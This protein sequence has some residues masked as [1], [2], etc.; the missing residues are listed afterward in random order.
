MTL[1]A[2]LLDAGGTLL[3]EEPS[4]EAL[5]AQAATRRG[6]DLSPP[7]MRQCMLRAHAALPLILDGNFRYS[8][9]WFE[10]FIADV[11]LRQLGLEP[12]RLHALVSEL[13]ETFADAANFR[14]LPGA[15]ELL[16]GAKARGWKLGLISNWSESM[17]E[18]LAGLG[19]LPLFDSVLI[20]AIER[21]E[22]PQREIFQRALA[23]LNVRADEALHLGN[24]PVQDVRGATD[25]G[26][27]ALLFDPC[28]E[29]VGLGVARVRS[30]SE[31][32][33]W[34]EDPR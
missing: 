31:V 10:A 22:K 32:I 17:P 28:D 27:R 7:A 21:A 2:L 6:L 26:I 20:S 1:K 3:T 19:I 15:R 30:L 16:E 18:V 24:Q 14:L 13:F 23:R 5:Y 29:H 9:A 33:P 8:K 34:I 25:C 11:F 4:R 12:A